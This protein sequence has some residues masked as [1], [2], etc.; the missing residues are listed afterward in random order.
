MW[1]PVKSGSPTNLQQRPPRES[2]SYVDDE[3]NEW[4]SPLKLTLARFFMSFLAR[5]AP[6]VEFSGFLTLELFAHAAF[7]SCFLAPIAW[8]FQTT[9]VSVKAEL[10]KSSWSHAVCRF[11]LCQGIDA[12]REALN[13]A[14][15]L[16]FALR[17]DPACFKVK[18][19]NK[20]Y[21]KAATISFFCFFRINIWLRLYRLLISFVARRSF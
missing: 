8:D 1:A 13:R 10:F 15:H 9:T 12:K 4:E 19:V 3:D 20:N 14:D 2:L 5:T 17:T 18:P 21:S 6:A 11:A 7:Q 16:T